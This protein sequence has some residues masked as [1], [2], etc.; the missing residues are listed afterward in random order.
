MIFQKSIH[1]AESVFSQTRHDKKVKEWPLH[2]YSQPTQFNRKP[3]RLR[4]ASFELIWLWYC[5]PFYGFN[6]CRKGRTTPLNILQFWRK[7]K[8]ENNHA[9]VPPGSMPWHAGPPRSMH[10][11][12]HQC[13][14]PF[15]GLPCIST[16]RHAGPAAWGRHVGPPCGASIRGA[17]IRTRGLH[18]RGALMFAF[19]VG[20]LWTT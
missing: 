4:T 17:S 18:V 2:I 7:N 11:G 3:L 8:S 5:T 12:R 6:P 9:R 15:A 13:G 14:P 1:V 10:A 19:C 20:V 16:D